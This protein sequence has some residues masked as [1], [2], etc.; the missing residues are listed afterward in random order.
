MSLSSM[1][2]TDFAKHILGK[3]GR[4][5]RRVG[6]SMYNH[7]IGYGTAALG[8]GT[9]GVGLVHTARFAHNVAG[10]IGNAVTNDYMTNLILKAQAGPL[11][12]S[13][14]GIGMR[15]HN[16]NTAGLTLAAHYARN[17]GKYFGLMGM[18]YL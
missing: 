15:H 18:R 10:E 6:R 2:G 12:P 7:P 8:A 16:A 3:G 17:R 14:S 11:G 1:S 4:G 9:L 13:G 5:L